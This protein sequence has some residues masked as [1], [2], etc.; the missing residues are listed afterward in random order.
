MN[1]PKVEE[2]TNP[3]YDN[4]AEDEKPYM[5]EGPRKTTIEQKDEGPS[6]QGEPTMAEIPMALPI[7]VNV[8][9]GVL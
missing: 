1:I 5:K 7:M 2:N 6:N 3:N 9:V 4:K 8:L